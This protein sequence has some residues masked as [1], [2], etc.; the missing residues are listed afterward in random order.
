VDERRQRVVRRALVDLTVW[1]HHYRDLEE[2]EDLREAIR[3]VCAKWRVPVDLDWVPAGPHRVFTQVRRGREIRIYVMRGAEITFGD[4]DP[5]WPRSRRGKRRRSLR[6]LSR[7]WGARGRR[8]SLMPLVCGGLRCPRPARPG[9]GGRR[10]L[11]GEGRGNHH[12]RAHGGPVLSPIERA[13]EC[14]DGRMGVRRW[15]FPPAVENEFA[16]YDILTLRVSDCPS[17]KEF[18]RVSGHEAEGEKHQG[19]A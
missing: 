8:T 4:I 6:P 17:A 7:S 1:Q 16:R 11:N 2:L 19:P 18:V 10:A 9:G 3:A 12:D 15:H 13:A 14:T 5:S